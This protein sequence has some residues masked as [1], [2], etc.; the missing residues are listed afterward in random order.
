MSASFLGTGSMLTVQAPGAVGARPAACLADFSPEALLEFVV[1]R[2][3][4]APGLGSSICASC[5][6]V[7]VHARNGM[8]GSVSWAGGRRLD[9]S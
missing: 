1:S 2:A 6:T 9:R 7:F 3:P 5:A 4:L 8:V